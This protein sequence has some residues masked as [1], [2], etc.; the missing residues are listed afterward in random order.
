MYI[1]VQR[2][3]GE[4]YYIRNLTLR[5]TYMY[6]YPYGVD[7][8]TPEL[9]P[10]VDIKVCGWSSHIEFGK[11]IFEASDDHGTYPMDN[12]GLPAG[13]NSIINVSGG[14]LIV[15]NA[16]FNL[17]DAANG[18]IHKAIYVGEGCS[19][20]FG[21]LTFEEDP[22]INTNGFITIGEGGANLSIGNVTLHQGAVFRQSLHTVPNDSYP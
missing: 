9:W 2:G 12:S 18:V 7:K 6:I 15:L 4:A 5:N 17:H 14:E 13:N 21:N 19:A 22:G 20:R 11:V 1:N 10:V 3:T 16:I 8:D